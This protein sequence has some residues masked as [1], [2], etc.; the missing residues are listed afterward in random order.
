[1]SFW[2]AIVLAVGLLLGGLML[3]LVSKS[4][5]FPPEKED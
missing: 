2:I 5:M 3:W 1:M 4:D